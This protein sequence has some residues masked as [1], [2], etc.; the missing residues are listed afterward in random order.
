M[1]GSLLPTDLSEPLAALRRSLAVE[2]TELSILLHG[3]ASP[4]VEVR[5]AAHA[6][7]HRLAGGLGFFGLRDEGELAR[8]ID[9]S[10]STD[11]GLWPLN[12]LLVLIRSIEQLLQP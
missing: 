12:E 8:M 10:F 7:V 6:S 5:S 2:V 3:D 1:S 9:E 4:T 11:S